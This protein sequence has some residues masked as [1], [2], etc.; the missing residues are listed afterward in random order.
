MPKWSEKINKKFW[1]RPP[2]LS[3]KERLLLGPQE[4]L[5]KNPGSALKSRNSVKNSG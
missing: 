5:V 4:P 2:F 3:S 1:N